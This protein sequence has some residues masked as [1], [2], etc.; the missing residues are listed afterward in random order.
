M[1]DRLVR[2]ISNFFGFSGPRARFFA[3]LLPV[4]MFNGLMAHAVPSV[5]TLSITPSTTVNA[6][7]V[8]T[9]TANVSNGSPVRGQV[10]FCLA[11][12]AY[13]TGNSVIASVQTTILGNAVYRSVP[14]AGSYSIKAVFHG[15]NTVASS[16]SAAQ[17]LTVNG[18]GSY[19][20]RT[21]IA[22][23][24]SPG[25]YTLTGTVT[26][27]GKLPPSGTVTFLNTT[28]ANAQIS[29]GIID[30]A[31]RSSNF[32]V[33]PSTPQAVS[34]GK[35]MKGDFNNDGILDLISTGLYSDGISI[36][37]GNG[38]G[39]FQT[40][41]GYSAGAKP[42]GIGLADL[43]GDGNIDIVVSNYNPV[44][45]NPGYMTVLL[46]NGDGTFQTAV[47]YNGGLNSGGVALGDFNGDGLLD[48]VLMNSGNIGIFIGNGDGT[49]QAQVT[50]TV[51]QGIPVAV[52][53]F[54]GD[55]KLD[56][57]VGDQNTSIGILL[58][59][60]DGTFQPVITYSAGYTA[61]GIVI[62]DFN[63]D[64]K[65]DI[66]TANF[67]DNTMGVL[68]GMG[69]G[70]FPTNVSYSTGN[71]SQP[72]DIAAGDF[73]GD[74]IQDLAVSGLF[75]ATSSHVFL[76]VGDGTFQ[77]SIGVDTGFYNLGIT[78][79]DFNGDGL[80]D[81]ATTNYIYGSIGVELSQLAVTATATGVTVPGPGTQNVDAS[82][83]GDTPHAAS[84]STTIPLQPLPS[85]TILAASPTSA[86]AGTA[87]N[88]TATV[89]PTPSG[90][91]TAGTVSFYS[92]SMLLSTVN[93]LVPAPVISP[94]VCEPGVLQFPQSIRVTVY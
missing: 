18:T 13:C 14:G 22:S 80:D 79:G 62:G 68:L 39:T 15:T 49:F 3:M 12:A 89:S 41:V 5:T 67:D 24:G 61:E 82:Y 21:S 83:E 53:D 23:S 19:G 42:F 92:G 90:S 36:A 2:S 38:D 27:F 51:P 34:G 57:A 31:T 46:G 77:A 86:V 69:D 85:S 11:S 84:L 60:G 59:N 54:N 64:G 26:G 7:T 91:G 81:F 40:P 45:P 70:T 74:G 88:F 48:A 10:D 9:M 44:Q 1:L 37:L 56:I 72:Y 30:A 63:N 94:R 4:I 29:S 65:L 17:T 78:A 32:T 76:G 33:P 87:I 50:Y 25:N 66:A 16:S 6:G 47:T 75:G 71:N 93:S 28:A 55:G 73:N 43:N 58:G 20:T 52:G 35:V 8:V